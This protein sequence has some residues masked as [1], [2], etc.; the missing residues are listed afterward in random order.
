[1]S[2]GRAGLRERRLEQ[3]CREENK[4]G[5]EDRRGHLAL[6]QILQN[7]S[8]DA[9]HTTVVSTFIIGIY[10]LGPTTIEEEK[11]EVNPKGPVTVLE[12]L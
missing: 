3:S 4:P 8:L 5:V 12:R 9:L 10:V 2:R 6:G 1:M 11:K 7:V